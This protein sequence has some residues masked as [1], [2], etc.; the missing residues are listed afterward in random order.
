MSKQAHLSLQDIFLIRDQIAIGYDDADRFELVNA[1]G[2]ISALTTP[3]QVAFDTPAFPSTIDKAAALTFLL[4]SNHPF[5][6]GNKRI[7]SEALDLF[8]QRNGLHLHANRDEREDL[9]VLCT[10]AHLRDE[11]ISTWIHRHSSPRPPRHPT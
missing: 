10:S 6:D 8:L 7:A 3:F 1:A 9:T 11:R 2:L 5:R 4:V